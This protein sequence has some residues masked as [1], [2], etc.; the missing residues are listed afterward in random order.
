MIVDSGLVST[1]STI[2]TVW[3][4]GVT[5]L[6]TMGPALCMRSC[7]NV[8][9]VHPYTLVRHIVLLVNFIYYYILKSIHS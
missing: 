3:R 5:V 2:S 9:A 8:G 4:V 7:L 6:W 1:V